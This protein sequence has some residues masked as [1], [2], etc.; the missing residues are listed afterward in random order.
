MRTTALIPF[1]LLLAA[2]VA[3]AQGTS[4]RPETQADLQKEA[5]MTMA[6]ARA[7]ALREVPHQLFGL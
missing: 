3:G 5:K 6:D 1:A 4:R 2:S 7:M